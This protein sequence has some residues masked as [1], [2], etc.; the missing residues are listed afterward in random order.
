MSNQS[1]NMCTQA[2]DGIE[3]PTLGMPARTD[4]RVIQV[5]QMHSKLR[6]KFAT[7]TWAFPIHQQTEHNF[8]R[9]RRNNLCLGAIWC[10][11]MFDHHLIY[12]S[13]NL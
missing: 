8:S 1:Y 3:A 4:H 12:L 10:E 5:V 7:Q 11:A 6:L 13:Y 2:Y 9:T